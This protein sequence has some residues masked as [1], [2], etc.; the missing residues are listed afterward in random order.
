MNE[1]IRNLHA[2]ARIFYSRQAKF[3]AAHPGDEDVLL[4]R[5]Y[6]STAPL[7]I[8][9]LSILSQFD[10][11]YGEEDLKFLVKSFAESLAAV[12]HASIE[13][14]SAFF[15][16]A[17]DQFLKDVRNVIQVGLINWQ[18]EKPNAEIAILLS[19]KEPVFEFA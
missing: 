16:S 5:L 2:L 3:V 8:D 14:Q 19:R 6:D 4:K 11:K 1:L 15:Y 10:P 7:Y 17:F 13:V 12:E 18:R 9:I